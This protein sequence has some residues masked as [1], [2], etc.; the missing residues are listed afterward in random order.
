MPRF[1]YKLVT[2][3]GE[4]IQGVAEAASRAA[5]LE[6]LRADGS[7]I[8]KAGELGG[9]AMG[10]LFARHAL[11]GKTLSPKD[12][13]LFT[14]ELATLLR[15]GLPIDRALATIAT[16]DA[17]GPKR[18]L[19]SRTLES[20]RGGASFADALE[21][22]HRSLPGFYIGMVRAGEAG[23]S[24]ETVLK[25]LAEAMQEA[26]AVRESVRSALHYPVIVLAVAAATL[27][28]LLTAVVPEFRSILESTGVP[29]P[30]SSRIVIGA[31]EGL[32]RAW[33]VFAAAIG[34][35]V[36]TIKW[37]TSRP[38]GRRQWDRLKLRTPLLAGIIV[39]LEVA[40]FSR[41]LSNLLVNGV[42]ILK[43][44]SI[45]SDT[46]ENRF[47]AEKIKA[48][49][50]QLNKGEGLA[51]P[52]A[53]SG[54]FPQLALQLVRVGEESGELEGMLAQVAEIYEGEVKRSVER[55]LA[56]LVPA[57]TIGLGLLV[58]GIIGSMLSA[59]LSAYRLPF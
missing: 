42:T 20:I 44:V 1:G 27:A 6:Q 28:I 53:N 55:L 21:Q 23:G 13:L 35:I 57:I 37:H 9:G 26:T 10:P 49:V 14:R 25:R 31:G 29:M 12:L 17:D 36:V 24:L 38:T 4:V 5:V 34:L 11:A 19:A 16:V 41:T 8:I 47:L 2:P 3:A 22:H 59:I 7:V 18:K 43:A 45:A 15:A 48:T 56:L 50:L 33:W 39:K 54:V 46:I 30:L 40:R 51:A 52:L 32:Q 58:A